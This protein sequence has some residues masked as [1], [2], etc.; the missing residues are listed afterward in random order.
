M[1]IVSCSKPNSTVAAL[2]LRRN[3]LKEALELASQKEAEGYQVRVTDAAT[4]KE[5]SR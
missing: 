2:G 5:L 1:Y 4:G 3:T